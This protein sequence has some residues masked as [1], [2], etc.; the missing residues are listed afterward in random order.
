M[1]IRFCCNTST[2]KPQPL[3]RK[4]ELTAAAGEGDKR[5]WYLSLT[6]SLENLRGL[7]TRVE[8][9]RLPEM[10]READAIAARDVAAFDADGL[11]SEIESRRAAH[12][13][14]VD[15]Y[16]QEFI[17]LAHGIRLFGQFHNDIVR[18]DDPYEFMELLT[19][20]PLLS[21][22]RNRELEEELEAIDAIRPVEE[23]LSSLMAEKEAL[24]R[25]HCAIRLE[26]Q[27]LDYSGGEGGGRGLRIARGLVE[28]RPVAPDLLLGP[29]LA[30]VGSL[31]EQA[32]DIG[33]QR[34]QC[35][36][37]HR[38]RALG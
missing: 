37:M 32:A 25:R 9:E 19:A 11:A 29:G 8:D 17:P 2:I 36:G 23:K 31:G 27:R 4:I 15:I 7:R 26:L 12:D 38:Q 22:R 24:E 5:A 18:P 6:R 28:G 1:P 30:E 14:W 10:D 34:S 13:R 20:T 33:T 3:L 21:V 16:W 35:I